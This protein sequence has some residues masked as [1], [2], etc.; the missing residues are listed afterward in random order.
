MLWNMLDFEF[1]I[2]DKIWLAV[3]ENQ[4]RERAKGGKIFERFCAMS[5]PES[6][7]ARYFST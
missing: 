4:T 6:R 7:F 2:H 3:P 5:E 1:N